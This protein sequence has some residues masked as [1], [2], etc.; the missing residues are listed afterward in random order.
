M[1]KNLK[2]SI[3]AMSIGPFAGHE[4]RMSK[5]FELAQEALLPIEL[6]ELPYLKYARTYSCLNLVTRF[7][8]DMYPNWQITRE[9]FYV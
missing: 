6:P 4:S 7:V 3:A 5:V 9:N 2:V 8:K 1:R